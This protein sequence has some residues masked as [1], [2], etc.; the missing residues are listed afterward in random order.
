MRF[1]RV[2][3]LVA[4]FSQAKTAANAQTPPLLDRAVRRT[5]SHA[6]KPDCPSAA[7]A[8]YTPKKLVSFPKDPS[9][10]MLFVMVT[11]HGAKLTIVAR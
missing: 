1:R 4:P 2:G 6:R 8:T 11:R 5:F 9:F 3:S 7:L 10:F